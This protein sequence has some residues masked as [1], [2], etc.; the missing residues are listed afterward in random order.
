MT[1]ATSILVTFF[2]LDKQNARPPR[3]GYFAR[4]EG[5]G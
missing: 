2:F 1:G 5:A 3:S 4:R